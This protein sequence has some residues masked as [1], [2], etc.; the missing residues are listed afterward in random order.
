MA[1]GSENHC[2]PPPHALETAGV[3]H[4]AL[5]T[6]RSDCTNHTHA[7]DAEMKK[8]R[9]RE[10][11]E[12]FRANHHSRALAQVR[13]RGHRHV[14]RQHARA[15]V[16]AVVQ[17]RHSAPLQ[18]RVSPLHQPP[19]PLH[20]RQLQH[21]VI[22]LH[23]PVNSKGQ[24]QTYESISTQLNIPNTIDMAANVHALKCNRF[25]N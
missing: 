1:S 3:L 14:V 23:H 10:G 11:E 2:P 5:H 25:H 13:R 4:G 7:S 15:V 20:A 12:G 18:R 17:G 19:L 22:E 6:T 8:T 16:P 21:H 24:N 9:R